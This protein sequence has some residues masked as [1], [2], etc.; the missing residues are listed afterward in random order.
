MP[1]PASRPRLAAASLLLLLL[2]ALPAP[3][4]LTIPL[5]LKRIIAD[6]QLIFAAVVDRVDP[7]KPAA[8][9]KLDG[10]LKGEP[11]FDR[12]PVNLT[13]DPAANKKEDHR[14]LILDRLEPGR[15]LLV[16][17]HKRGKRYEAMGFV[18]GTWFSLHGSVDDDGKTVRWAFQSCEPYLR[19]T[20]KG[21]TAELRKVVEDALAKRAEPPPLDDKEPP[22]Y[23]PP[24]KKQP[25]EC[26]HP[27]SR[28]RERPEILLRGATGGS[29]ARAPPA[30]ATR[31]QAHGRA[32]R[33]WHPDASLLRSLA[34]RVRR[35]CSE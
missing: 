11:P 3:A 21:T 29:P 34:L 8:V 35:R 10:K 27:A 30:C 4:L 1:H 13:G 12:L 24:V 28:E 7:D 33:P 20:F 16:F 5:P 2:A 15:K 23:G 31:Q 32:S 18:E 22:G 19:R 26:D 14:K 6:E 9:F 17:A 25:E